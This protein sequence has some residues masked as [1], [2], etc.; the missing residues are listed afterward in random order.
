MSR[1]EWR[2]IASGTSEAIETDFIQHLPAVIKPGTRLSQ[3][4][5]FSEIVSFLYPGDKPEIV[6]SQECRATDRMARYWLD[7]S[8]E[9]SGSAKLFIVAEVVR[10]LF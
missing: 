10:R 4:K 2:S 7:G 3:R 1:E 5:F 9:P 6:L 8:S